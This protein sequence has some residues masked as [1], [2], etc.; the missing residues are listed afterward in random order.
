MKYSYDS[1]KENS[2]ESVA[3]PKYL[4][5]LERCA[6]TYTVTVEIIAGTINLLESA[7][8]SR[9]GVPFL[10][11]NFGQVLFYNTALN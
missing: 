10:S 3:K 5:L 2:W 8:I 11:L 4:I 1:W 9:L 7:H 6:G